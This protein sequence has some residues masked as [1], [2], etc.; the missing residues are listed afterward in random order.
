[1]L[2]SADYQ[3]GSG[4]WLTAS[5]Q[6]QDAYV[7][8]ALLESEVV[9]EFV[10]YNQ[11]EYGGGRR[12]AKDIEILYSNDNTQFTLATTY[13]LANSNGATPNPANIIPISNGVSAKYWRVKLK[14][15]WA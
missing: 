4:D 7:T 9:N 13:T 3:S 8:F 11:N 6:R 10:I 15:F 12:D 14:S 1:M 2:G 5:G